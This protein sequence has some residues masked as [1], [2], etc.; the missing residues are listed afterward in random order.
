MS[1][2]AALARRGAP[3]M[4]AAAADP[5]GAT[6]GSGGAARQAAAS[7]GG[8][9]DW[10]TVRAP[11][12]GGGRGCCAAPRGAFGPPRGGGGAVGRVWVA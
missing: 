3:A 8:Y 12:R 11:A 5:L 2:A 6:L 1:R 10:E 7:G 9:V 4:A